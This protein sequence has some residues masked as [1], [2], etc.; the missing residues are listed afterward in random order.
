MKRQS[1]VKPVKPQRGT[2]P[3]LI[4][5]SV[6]VVLMV[7]FAPKIAQTPGRQ[8]LRHGDRSGKPFP[9]ANTNLRVGDVLQPQRVPRMRPAR[10]QIGWN[11]P[12]PATARSTSRATVFPTADKITFVFPDITAAGGM[13]SF[14]LRRTSYEERSRVRSTRNFQALLQAVQALF[15]L[16]AAASSFQELDLPRWIPNTRAT[17]VRQRLHHHRPM[18]RRTT[19]RRRVTPQFRASTV[20][21]SGALVINETARPPSP[22][23][24]TRTAITPTG[25][26]SATRPIRRSTFPTTRSATARISSLVALPQAP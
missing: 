10:F 16:L 24:R 26:R 19:T 21:Q 2:L 18:R 13:S 20:L 12:T 3:L 7:L 4:A 11:S 8:R 6:F 23:S 1:A 5:L 22:R 25:S 14:L 9:A 15:P 17:W